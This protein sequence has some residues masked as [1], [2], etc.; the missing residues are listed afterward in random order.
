M[1]TQCAWCKRVKLGGGYHRFP[2]FRKMLYG[3]SLPLLLGLRVSLKTTHS[4]C[5]EC[6]GRVL[7]RYL[8]TRGPSG[9]Q[10][11]LSR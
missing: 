5:P 6:A 4:I 1:V 8:E 10:A 7:A 9:R 3:Y 11:A 2:G